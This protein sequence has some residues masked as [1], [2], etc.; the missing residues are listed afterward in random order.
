M[1]ENKELRKHW[2]VVYSVVLTVLIYNL[3][4]H[5][6][7]AQIQYDLGEE[8]RVLIRTFLYI[9]AIVLLP[10]TNLLRF[11]LIRLN[12][13]MPGDKSAED[14]YFITIVW[15][16]LVIELIASFGLIMFILGDG[17]NTLYI[18]SVIALLGA[19]LHRPKQQDLDG[20]KVALQ[21]QHDVPKAKR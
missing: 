4:C 1:A 9:A 14:R 19:G 16:Q 15:T 8:Q 2:W 10:L 21:T 20:I 3:I 13:T 18:F 12:Q 6:F 5:Y 17:Y 7:D 11:V